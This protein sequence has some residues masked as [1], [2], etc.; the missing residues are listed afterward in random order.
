MTNNEINESIVNDCLKYTLRKPL[1]Y[2]VANHLRSYYGEEDWWAEGVINTLSGDQVRDLPN[3]GDWETLV[4]K[5][6]IARSLELLFK[7]KNEIF[8]AKLPRAYRSIGIIKG[9]RNTDAHAG[10]EGISYAKSISFLDAMAQLLE[11]IGESEASQIARGKISELKSDVPVSV[12]PPVDIPQYVPPQPDIKPYEP[13]R[14]VPLANIPQYVPPQYSHQAARKEPLGCSGVC[15]IIFGGISI[16]LFFWWAFTEHPTTTISILATIPVAI[17]LLIIFVKKTVPFLRTVLGGVKVESYDNGAYEGTMLNGQR[18]GRGK[19]TWKDGAVHIGY[20]KNGNRRGKGKMFYANGT[21]YEGV[22]K[23]NFR[24]GNGKQT[25]AD[26]GVYIGDWENDV[27]S[28]FGRLIFASGANYNGAWK[29]D[30]YHGKG[31]MLFEDDALYTGSW[32]NGKMNG[33]GKLIWRNG[34]IYTGYFENGERNGRCKLIYAD[35]GL[36]KGTMLNGIRK[37]GK[38]EC[39]DG[40]VFEGFFDEDGDPQGE[41]EKIPIGSERDSFNKRLAKRLEEIAIR[42]QKMESLCKN[43]VIVNEEPPPV[44]IPTCTSCNV[45]LDETAIFC[46]HCGHDIA[47]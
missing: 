37:S 16:S 5:L 31:T 4:P 2:F 11:C 38:V 8:Y 40:D 21:V 39:P 47:S 14:A 36:F 10:S 6:D 33:K 46:I 22:W 17:I 43:I 24:H 12:A 35:G 3:L 42:A 27:R 30:M 29:D 45:E 9:A 15:G 13:V 23:N 32:K 25:Y 28:G 18:H 7:H 41:Y 34:G 26:D 1:A 19:Y 44:A 20:W